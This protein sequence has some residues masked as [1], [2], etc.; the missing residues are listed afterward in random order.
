[1]V[2]KKLLVSAFILCT[3]AAT[4]QRLS[5]ADSITLYNGDSLTLNGQTIQLA[6]PDHERALV[7]SRMVQNREGEWKALLNLGNIARKTGELK[8]AVTLLQEAYSIAE[9]LQ[10]A[11][12]RSQ[13]SLMLGSVQFNMT[14]YDAALDYFQKARN[15]FAQEKDTIKM[16][17]ALCNIG[18]VLL[19]QEKG[20]SAMMILQQAL[21]VFE[22]LKHDKGTV[23][24]LNSMGVYYL[25]NEQPERALLHLQ[26]I[27]VNDY[28]DN[29]PLIKGSNFMNIGGAYA[30]LKKYGLAE[31]YLFKA[32]QNH[33][34][35]HIKTK[36]FL[37]YDALS[38]L[39][40]TLGHYKAAFDYQQKH[41]LLK[42]S[43]IGAENQQ[44]IAA[45]ELQYETVAKEQ[46]LMKS[47]EELRTLQLAQKTS[48]L[49]NGFIISS[50]LALLLA[51]FLLQYRLKAKR[52]KLMQDNER[53]KQ[54]EE[55]ARQEAVEMKQAL[56][57]KD[58][59]LTYF[60]LDIARKNDIAAQL[61]ASLDKVEKL[62]KDHNNGDFRE[63]KTLIN[64]H[65]LL[66]EEI[67]VLQGNV[68]TI[69]YGFYRTLKEKYPALTKNDLQLCGLL[70]L[71]L[72]TKDIASMRGVET[73]SIE[74]SRYRLRKKLGLDKGADLN[75][76]M[77]NFQLTQ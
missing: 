33:Q 44:R 61:T 60:A 34:E 64:S 20:D 38:V 73:K 37:V 70:R 15:I 28:L 77:M 30:D 58:Q 72:S 8:T 31:T 27:E 48:R 59:D 1:M 74:M 21:S 40:Q 55:E 19:R 4:A 2:M 65:H 10:D 23:Y 39:N 12:K 45:L 13:I 57:N 24:T 41:Y 52:I 67:G 3:V 26:K 32:L 68:D 54:L 29:D 42:D 47:E 9:A 35:H 11:N 6:T 49:R 14:N 16:G 56:Q 75:E 7:L 51:G 22:E 69:N 46:A 53:M 71:N 63:L 66:N 17:Y 18:G 76:L 62:L 36:E 5:I 43:I 50:L 25:D